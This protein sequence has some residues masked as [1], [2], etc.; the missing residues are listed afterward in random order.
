M[1]EDGAAK[2]SRKRPLRRHSPVAKF[3]A[4][5][6]GD[7]MLAASG[8]LIAFS[9]LAFAGYML[10]DTDA[11]PRIA[12]LEYLSI[13]ARP[14][15]S[16]AAAQPPAPP[17]EEEPP[18]RLAEQPIDPT[19]TGS[20]PSKIAS[21]QPVNLVLTPLRDADPKAPH[22]SYKLL[23]VSDGEAL[24]QSD[25]GFRQVKAGDILPDLG[26]INAIERRGDHWVLLS[27]KGAALESTPP[28]AI[29]GGTITTKGKTSPR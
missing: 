24:I 5:S 25:V 13:F 15:H 1:S 10:A 20:I 7:R 18:A 28:S 2:A 22:V 12:G 6:N 26:R 9:S 8:V 4:G 23:D 17:V 14:S 16:I 11:P 21:G 3:G 29:S 27:Q 19:P